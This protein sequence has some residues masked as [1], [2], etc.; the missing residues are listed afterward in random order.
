MSKPDD[1]R[2]REL[3]HLKVALATFALHLDVFEMQAQEVMLSIGRQGDHAA[4]VDIG[5]G[6]PRKDELSGG[7]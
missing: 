1:P 6:K 7:Q 5:R 2:T 3:G 4:R